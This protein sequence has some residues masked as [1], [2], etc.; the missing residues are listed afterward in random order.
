MYV[1]FPT[2]AL[3]YQIPNCRRLGSLRRVSNDECRLVAGAV[4]LQ[5][6]LNCLILE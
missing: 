4:E 6:F 1:A 3:L 2:R 5:P